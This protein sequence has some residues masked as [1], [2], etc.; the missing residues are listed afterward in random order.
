M[1]FA[2]LALTAQLL[3]HI[4]P[5]GPP[6][7]AAVIFLPGD[8][9][10]RGAAVS[11]GHTISSLGYDVYG[12]DTRRYL[13]AAKLSREEMARDMRG[14]ASQVGASTHQPVLLVGWSQGAGMAVAAAS[15]N[16]R[17]GAIKGILTMG[18]PESAVLGW[19]WKA[20]VAVL[21]RRQPD[22]PS[23]SIQP[24]LAGVAP[25]PIW[26]IHGSEDE[27]TTPETARALFGA[28]SEPRHLD[29]I[30]GANHR[31][32]GHRDELYRSLRE[33]LAWLAR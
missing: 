4:A 1:I 15:G 2:A 24:L 8:G 26:M 23:F 9:G 31:F 14:L 32:D 11:M 20:T 22:Q 16:G 28:A 21:A 3:V 19:D 5:E 10:W 13:E 18:L 7:P 12:F 29:E 33:G 27:Y 25:A 6:A 17:C 30:A